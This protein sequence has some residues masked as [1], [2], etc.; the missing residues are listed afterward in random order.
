M[1]MES[2]LGPMKTDKLKLSDFIDENFFED[3]EAVSLTLDATNG[4]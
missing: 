1:F 3:I 4:F 2:T